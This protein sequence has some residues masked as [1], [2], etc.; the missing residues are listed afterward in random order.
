MAMQAARHRSAM[1]RAA[2]HGL[3]AACRQP[4]FAALPSQLQAQLLRA[5][6]DA[7]QRDT[8]PAVRAAA[9]RAIGHIG[10]F[11]QLTTLAG[12]DNMGAVQR[13]HYASEHC[14]KQPNIRSE[15]CSC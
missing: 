3:S 10:S 8:L 5:S 15:V 7:A 11:P 12:V 13:Q 14:P 9:C 4:V 1:V 2:A 6:S